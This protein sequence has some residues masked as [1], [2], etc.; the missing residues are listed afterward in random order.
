MEYY[1]EVAGPQLADEFYEELRAF[2]R[3]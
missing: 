1:E 3:R 2:A